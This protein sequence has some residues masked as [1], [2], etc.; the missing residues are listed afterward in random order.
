MRSLI[1][2]PLVTL[3]ALSGCA[4]QIAESRVRSALVNVGVDDRGASCMANRMVDRLSIKQLRKLEALSGID[5]GNI[6][7]LT[8]RD[9]VTRVERIGDPE[10]LA[11]VST[12]GVVCALQG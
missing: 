10:V 4:Q 1:A 9:F 8:I 2:L 12:S 6:G 3:V 11:V 7:S 5:R